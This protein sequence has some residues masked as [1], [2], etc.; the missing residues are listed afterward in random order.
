MAKTI[1][2]LVQEVLHELKIIAAEETAPASYAKIVEARYRERL[3]T[4][5]KDEYADWDADAIPDEA[6]PGLRLVIANECATP[7]GRKG[8][9]I[10][11][12]PFRSPEHEGLHK[13]R[14]YM[15][16]KP[17]YRPVRAAYY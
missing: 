4:L 10:P 16:I 6:M 8:T 2:D 11:T 1:Q 7:F 15:R 5:T 3:P 13:L 14:L 17:T 9:L 12:P